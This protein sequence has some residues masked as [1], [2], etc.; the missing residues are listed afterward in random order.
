[1]LSSAGQ[2]GLR[3]HLDLLRSWSLGCGMD[4][5][6]ASMIT[7]P[8]TALNALDAM[9]QQGSPGLMQADG[10]VACCTWAGCIAFPWP[11]LH[12]VPVRQAPAAGI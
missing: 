1:M 7:W 9:D 3:M 6:L 5:E 12:A 8:G 4:P 2:A 11:N 10:C